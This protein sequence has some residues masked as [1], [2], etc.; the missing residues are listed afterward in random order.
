M[1]IENPWIAMQ[2]QSHQIHPNG[3]PTYLQEQ[4]GQ[5]G[6]DLIL[7]GIIKSLFSSLYLRPDQIFYLD[8]GANHPIQ[9][10]NTY[11]FA[12]KWKGHGVLVE[13]NPELIPTL[14][15]V[16]PNDLI[17]NLAV[18][19]ENNCDK[20]VL[21]ISKHS[22]L[23]S[24]DLG[25]LQ[26]F[27]QLSELAKQ[28]EVSAI[29][30]D[31]LLDRYCEST[32]HLMSIDIEGVD[33]D[34]LNKASFSKRP[35]LI[36]TEPSRHYHHN[37][38]KAFTRVMSDKNYFEL[39]RTD[40]NLIYVDK[41]IFLS[42]KGIN[43]NS[44]LGDVSRVQSFDIFDTLIARRCIRPEAVFFEVERRSG[45]VGF[46]GLRYQAERL[47]EANEYM[48][49]DIYLE[50]S[51]LAICDASNTQKLME[52]EI[53]VELE[54]VVPIT[55]NLSQVKD[56][57]LLIT[58]MYLPDDVIRKMLTIAGLPEHMCL[59]RSSHG[60]RNGRVWQALA[61]SNVFCEHLGDNEVADHLRPLD[62][63][64]RTKLTSVAKLTPTEQMFADIGALKL[65]EILRASRLTTRRETLSELQYKL[66]T[67]FNI[68]ILLISALYISGSFGNSNLNKVLFSSRDSRYLH[69]LYEAIKLIQPGKQLQSEYWYTSRIAR[70]SREPS[71]LDYCRGLFEGGALLVDLCG[72]GASIAL[73]RSTLGITETDTPL[74]LC[75]W[76]ESER[77]S[78]E[79]ANSYKI[80]AIASPLFL[81]T[82]TTLVPNEVLELLN[83]VPEGMV[84]SVQAVP[85]GFIPIR[86][87]VEF[88]EKTLLQVREQARFINDYSNALR[89]FIL[90]E[91]LDE[92]MQNTQSLTSCM[93]Q[94]AVGLEPEISGLIA[95]WLPEHRAQEHRNK[96]MLF[97]K[98]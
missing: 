27:G 40:Y 5:L 91:A 89:R 57:S 81:W 55:D 71:Y 23:S 39:A 29:T 15:Q 78:E 41:S 1:K 36:I 67:E 79:L 77:H 76:I 86:N 94:I 6:E 32:P 87:V 65:A 60:K 24:L 70:A 10:S 14:K 59:I 68:P 22:E 3:L 47:V 34:V 80:S 74:F 66:Q 95:A 69:S 16:R 20:V 8:I 12:N 97:R 11:L 26:S 37:A 25:H 62:V 42:L 72:T 92:V 43:L 88:S 52:L 84:R 46:A 4:Y 21:N 45:F 44:T 31:E 33:L 38:E 35:M 49:S 51:K 18:V 19:P 30:L 73:L 28:I 48:L 2:C 85:G 63:G 56:D 50:I 75:E 98:K 58:D 93:R 17:L 64:M 61:D 82:N 83:Y 13:A 96:A 90:P 53:Q 7:E 9:T 54:N